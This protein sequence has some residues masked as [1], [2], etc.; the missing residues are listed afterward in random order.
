[1]FPPPFFLSSPHSSVN[2]RHSFATRHCVFSGGASNRH[3]GAGEDR[4]PTPFELLPSQPACTFF[5][6]FPRRHFLLFLSLS[7][8]SLLLLPFTPTHLPLLFLMTA[9]FM[10][11]AVVLIRKVRLLLTDSLASTLCKKT[12]WWMKTQNTRN[13][14]VDLDFCYYGL[15][16]SNTVILS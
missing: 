6:N 15:S 4:G 12:K 10:G 3:L 8:F 9:V 5:N 14:P 7:L 11:K 16:L 1:M 2:E 13:L